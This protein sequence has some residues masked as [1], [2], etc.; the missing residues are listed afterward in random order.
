MILP[1][2]A[3]N[4]NSKNIIVVF[5]SFNKKLYEPEHIDHFELENSFANY[6]IDYDVLFVKDIKRG[7]WYLYDVETTSKDLQQ[8]TST[9]N[10]VVFTGIS[11]GGFASI[12]YG[13]LLGVNL[14]IAVNPQ[15]LLKDFETGEVLITPEMMLFDLLEKKPDIKKYID[16]KPHINKTTKYYLNGHKNAQK[17]SS[18]NNPGKLHDIK[19][20]EYLSDFPNVHWLPFMVDLYT[21]KG[22]VDLLLKHE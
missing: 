11:A 19:N 22:F 21:T 2:K 4:K 6:D 18:L 10:K 9:Y 20:Y 8:Y 7:Y 14:V 12:L 16:T 15:T 1:H 13:S 3:K 17:Y 5:Q